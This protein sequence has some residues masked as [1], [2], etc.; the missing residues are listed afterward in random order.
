V[1]P[2][3]KSPHVVTPK[4]HNMPQLETLVIDPSG[5]FVICIRRGFGGFPFFKRVSKLCI[6]KLKVATDGKFILE[7]VIQVDL[8]YPFQPNSYLSV[9]TVGEE[10]RVYIAHCTGKVEH[11]T[12]NENIF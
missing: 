4:P 2:D 3:S 5:H 8:H 10:I 7:E 1:D 11:Y 9:S 12:L 6:N